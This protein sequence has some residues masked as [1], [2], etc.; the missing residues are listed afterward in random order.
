MKKIRFLLLGLVS[1]LI[2]SGCDFPL[3]P[4]KTPTVETPTEQLTPI[5]PTQTIEFKI[6]FMVDSSIYKELTIQKGDKINLPEVPT[7]EGF[8]FKGWFLDDDFKQEYNINSTISSDITLY[9]YFEE[10]I[11]DDPTPVPVTY[12]VKFMN[13]ST[14]HSSETIIKGNVV[15]KPTNP[16]KEG[17]NFICWSTSSSS[18]QEFNFNTPITSD[19]TLYAYFEEIIVDD[20]TPEPVTYSVKFMNGSTLHSS[21][22]IIKDNVAEKP[23]NPTKEGFNF[24]CWSTSSSSKQEF[25]FNTPITSDLIL[26]AY[27]EEIIVDIPTPEPVTYSVTLMDGSA[28]HFSDSIVE[29]NKMTK[30][31]NPSKAGFNFICWSTSSSSKQEFDFNT[32]ITSDLILYAYYEE[33]IVEKDYQINITNF[34]G[35]N[36]GAFFEFDASTYSAKDFVVTYKKDGSTTTYTLDEELIRSSS[37]TIRCDILGLTKGSYSVTIKNTTADVEVTKTISVTEH[38]RS[39]YAHFDNNGGV[40][41]YND[42]GSLKSNAIVIYVNDLNKNTV[43]AKIGSK[44][45]TGLVSI[46]AAAKN[47]SY[48]ICVRLIGSVKTAQWNYKSHGAG[49][50][51]T[52][53]ANL[54]STFEN[55]RHFTNG[56]LYYSDI[57][58]L[59]YNSMS[60]DI[61]NGI[62]LL[63]GLTTSVS[64]SGGEYDSYYNMLDISEGS[65]ITIEGVGTDA[66]IYQW[67]FNFKKCNNIEVRNITFDRYTE[68]AIG[69]EG[70]KNNIS[71]Y[72]NYW[73]HNCKFNIGVNNWDVCYEADKGDGDGST[74]FKYCRGVTI[75]Y[76]EYVKTHKTILIGGSDSAT[77]YNFTLHHNYFNNCSSRLPLVRQTNIHLYNNYFYKTTGTSSSIRANCSMFAENNYY[78]NAKNP[79][80]V[81][82]T[83]T[84]TGT[85][86]KAYG[87]YFNNCSTSGSSDN[88]KYLKANNVTSRTETISGSCNP[89]GSKQLINFDTNSSLFYYDS[90]NK[91]S[92]VTNLLDASLVKEHCLNYSGVLKGEFVT[93]DTT[94]PD[95]PKVDEPTQPDTPETPD[96]PTDSTTKYISFDSFTVGK[97]NSKTTINGITLNTKTDKTV[98]VKSSNKTVDGQDISSYL[99]LS[100]GG[101][102]TELS[103][104]FDVNATS[105]ITVYFSSTGTSTRYPALYNSDGLVAKATTGS[106]SSTTISSFT[107]NNVSSGNY[108]LC[109]SSSGIN[110]FLIVI[111]NN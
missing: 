54:N 94:T 33:I 75:S 48:P 91:V 110:I 85:S 78:D 71:T 77:Q 12:S 107:F 15:E 23:T 59:G 98:E 68:D 18:K 44:T 28:V 84:Y 93:E 105:N 26:Y 27:F 43:T 108:S 6:T 95:T 32:P 35:Y 97:I 1:M 88:N 42:D 57:I 100:G 56:K 10:I 16:T 111:E 53:T 86:L 81:V 40:G 106:S 34:G 64:Y 82:T 19:I 96:T 2:L 92:D 20:P 31:T 55:A 90:I 66:V 60:N 14:L 21:E 29:G 9:A 65:N 37:D 24:I 80:N 104:N 52:R 38:D 4:P 39:G 50:T 36:E 61:N 8:E 73:I 62:T 5:E 67:G 13:G 74:D 70:E 89:T 87:N 45:Y 41:A 99:Y 47:S 103:V 3:N 101:S 17:F 76:C 7:K 22:T 109:S 102:Y 79:F 83:S 30:P 11:A 63:N 69:F 25:N 46:L 72:G 58:S 51:S 49:K